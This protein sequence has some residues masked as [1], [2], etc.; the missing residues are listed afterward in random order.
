MLR[1]SNS[2]WG[3]NLSLFSW[4]FS[5][6]Y[7]QL[8]LSRKPD[9]KS[10][11]FLAAHLTQL[12]C[13]LMT[14]TE[15]PYFASGEAPIPDSCD[16]WRC[17]SKRSN[18]VESQTPRPKAFLLEESMC[19]ESDQIFPSPRKYKDWR[20][21]KAVSTDSSSNTCSHSC[22]VPSTNQTTRMQSNQPGLP[23]MPPKTSVPFKNKLSSVGIPRLE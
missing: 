20:S 12:S 6:V 21:S 22:S 7:I 19:S 1:S 4:Y 16:N 18:G 8:W 9:P 17:L 11:G 13:P 23:E 10:L 14:A 3:C 2:C 5:A 15:G